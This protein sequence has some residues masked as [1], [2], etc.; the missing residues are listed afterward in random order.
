[1]ADPPIRR[2]PA[3]PGQLPY[4]AALALN[5]AVEATGG[6]QAPSSQAPPLA[7]R[8]PPAMGQY[9]ASQEDNFPEHVSAV[10]DVVFGP[11]DRP[12]EPITAGVPFG[13][14]SNFATS[15]LTP[16]EKLRVSARAVLNAKGVDP[17]SQAFFARVLNGE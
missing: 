17:R 11:T 13:P 16:Q 5:Q 1:M 7:R 12:D 8:P 14:G 4:G 9:S 2:G 10:E 3:E 6:F 15:A